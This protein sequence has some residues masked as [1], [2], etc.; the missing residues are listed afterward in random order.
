M[1]VHVGNFLMKECFLKYLKG[2]TIVI[3]THALYYLKYMD[4]VF[5]FENG[6]S[7]L[8]GTYQELKLVP[9][10]NDLLARIQKHYSNKQPSSE[11]II[12]KSPIL[13]EIDKILIDE[14]IIEDNLIIEENPFEKDLPEK[15]RLLVENYSI[16]PPKPKSVY[17]NIILEEDRKKGSL[18]SK[19]YTL[20][21]K[22]NGGVFFALILMVI[23]SC[24][25]ANQLATNLW[26]AHWSSSDD[27]ENHLFYLEIYL[28]LA[29]T[30]GFFS[31][32][33]SAILCFSNLK[34][35][36]KMHYLIMKRILYA[37]LNEFF[38]RV[39]AGRILNRISKDMSVVD[40]DIPFDIGNF[41]VPWFSFLGDLIFCV[42]STS[43]YMILPISFFFSLCF[44]VQS[45]YMKAYR[46][47]VRLESISRSPIVSYF[48]ESLSGLSSI[49]AYR[50]E[51]NFYEVTFIFYR[52]LNKFYKKRE[53]CFQYER[54]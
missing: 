38:E 15:Q 5:I 11:V 10:F 12:E 30:Y 20:Y 13:E 46:E 21:L 49:R 34:V 52:I 48:N 25:L 8:S 33:R 2:K 28:I 1:D 54:K 31:L 23:M 43:L 41:L 9:G 27:E 32:L 19:I 4:Y 26:L 50:K 44:W 47:L 35:S 6:Q 14:E 22:M 37:P 36:R 45:K 40:G 3:V 53:T 17:D 16:V 7:N 24:W 51:Q 42:Y 18:S 39:P 29:L